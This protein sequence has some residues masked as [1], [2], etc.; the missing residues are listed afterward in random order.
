MSLEVHLRVAGALLLALAALH[1][2]FPRRF[3][4]REE[5]ARLSMLNRQMF[6]G[7]CLFLVL[8]LVLLGL[9]MLG[10]PEALIERTVLGRAVALGLVV[11]WGLRLL[12]QWL[13]YDHALWRGRPFNMA[14]HIIFSGLLLYFLY[15]FGRLLM[16]QVGPTAAWWVERQ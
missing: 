12:A 6:V 5:L 11:F 1:A 8:L 2:G 14:V 13:F 10:L 16:W 9:L 4:W 15:V 7:H 3:H